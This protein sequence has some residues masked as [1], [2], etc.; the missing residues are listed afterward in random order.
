MVVGRISLN[1][2]SIISFATALTLG[3]PR[4][5]QFNLVSFPIY[6][7]SYHQHILLS[8]RDLGTAF[9]TYYITIT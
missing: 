1:A 2:P 9:A 6:Y 4:S 8:Q 3:L 5:I 7:V